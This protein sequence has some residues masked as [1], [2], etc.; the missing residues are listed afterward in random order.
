MP[1]ARPTTGAY[2]HNSRI[3]TATTPAASMVRWYRRQLSAFSMILHMH[4]P[5]LHV[6]P[7]HFLLLLHL[8]LHLLPIVRWDMLAS[9]YNV[10]QSLSIEC[11]SP[12]PFFVVLQLKYI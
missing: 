2:S 4:T 7:L 1:T 3:G 10:V 11:Q 12:L 6:L 9:Q 5:S 8:L